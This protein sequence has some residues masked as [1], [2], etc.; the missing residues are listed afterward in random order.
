[1]GFHVPLIRNPGLIDDIPFFAD[2]HIGL[3]AIMI[4]NK[5]LV[6]FLPFTRFDASMPWSTGKSNI[7]K[8]SRLNSLLFL[9][10]LLLS[11]F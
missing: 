5:D 6:H 10:F 8:Q 2:V 1:V 9:C 7:I 4:A 11:L 3:E